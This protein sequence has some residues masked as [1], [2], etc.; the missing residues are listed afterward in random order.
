MYD[1]ERKRRGKDRQTRGPALVTP[2]ITKLSAPIVADGPVRPHAKRHKPR[3]YTIHDT[4]PQARSTPDASLTR[5]VNLSPGPSST[6]PIFAANVE[7][8][9]PNHQPTGLPLIPSYPQRASP[10]SH[11]SFAPEPSL[12]QPLVTPDA[13]PYVSSPDVPMRP[14]LLALYVP[15]CHAI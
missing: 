15:R 12:S 1:T 3:P 8:G 7:S 10:L 14:G 9:S 11:I 13:A 2:L 5:S 6:V 4:A